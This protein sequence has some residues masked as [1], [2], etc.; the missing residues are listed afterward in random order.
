[1]DEALIYNINSLVKSDD[2]LW[3][4]G[5]FCFGPR[6]AKAFVKTAESYRNKINCNK[7]ILI[8]GNHDPKPFSHHREERQKAEGFR[9]L[10]SEDYSLCITSIGGRDV[11]LCH[12]TMARWD[13]SHQGAIH[14]Y[15][16]EHSNVES[17]MDEIMPG[18]KSMDVG[19]D[20]IK[21]IM[22][23]Y[24]PISF[25]EITSIMDKKPGFLRHHS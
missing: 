9:N 14:L 12:Y 25:Q 23:E 18:R 10:F 1:M 16:H 2:T 19:V 24:R 22:K 20:N 5:D 11:S 3:F 4:L 7:I 21:K 13:K 8:W 15:G 6:E 17:W